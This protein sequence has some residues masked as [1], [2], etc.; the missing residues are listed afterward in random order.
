MHRRA[1]LVAVYKMHGYTDV[2]SGKH[3][4]IRG[5]GHVKDC[6]PAS[7]A[8]AGQPPPK[9]V[10]VRKHP[11]TELWGPVL[12]PMQQ[13]PGTD[14]WKLGY[15]SVCVCGIQ[16]GVCTIGMGYSHPFSPQRVQA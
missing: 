2:L 15:M 10:R 13:F 16:M 14:T 9:R 8:N 7:S 12:Q 6:G 4:I 1:N 3:S 11:L 5:K